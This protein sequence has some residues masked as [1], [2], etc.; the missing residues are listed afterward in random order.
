VL[1]GLVVH[2]A[3]IR[4]HLDAELPF[5]ASEDILLAATAR[6]ADR[7]E[8]HEVIRRHSQAAAHAVKSEGKPN[9]LLARLRTEPMFTGLDLDRLLDASAYVG[10][11]PEQVDRFVREVADPIRAR[12]RD[13]LR[14]EPALRV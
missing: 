4:A 11:A 8:A 5:M 13:D 10:R 6:G 3:T 9:D 2:P 12:Y 1:G 14:E 7:Q